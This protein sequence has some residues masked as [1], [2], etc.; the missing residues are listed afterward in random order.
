MDEPT[1]DE[2][3]TLLDELRASPREPDHA[4]SIMIRARLANTIRDCL[5]GCRKNHELVGKDFICKVDLDRVF[6]QPYCLEE[7]FHG[8]LDRSQQTLVAQHYV[9]VVAILIWS[10]WDR[11]QDF[12]RDFLGRLHHSDVDLPFAVVPDTVGRGGTAVASRFRSDQYIFAPVILH[13]NYD[14]EYHEQ[15][16]L[17]LFEPQPLG[18]GAFGT[19]TKYRLAARHMV[20][21]NGSYETDAPQVSVCDILKYNRSCLTFAGLLCSMQSDPARTCHRSKKKWTRS[22]PPGTKDIA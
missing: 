13:A 15:L 14:A 7:F 10:H 4:T 5:E 6:L 18:K 8:L 22:F 1:R 19:V 11:W 12:A 21:Y 20:F 9:K 2:L 3:G 17:P 16:R